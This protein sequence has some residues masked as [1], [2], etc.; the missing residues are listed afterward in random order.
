MKQCERILV[1]L[2]TLDHVDELMDL[3]CRL[4]SPTASLRLVHVIELP[5]PTPLDAD[6]PELEAVAR[7]ILEKAESIAHQSAM[8]VSTGVF[9]A[10]SAASALFDELKTNKIELAILGYHHSRSIGEIL[11]GTT[12]Q[13]MAKHAPCRILLS[14]PAR[15]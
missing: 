3:A 12:A 5:D 2:K 7:E 15:A 10:H 14:I 11:L 9:R 8:K 4:G 1:G 6:V 13:H